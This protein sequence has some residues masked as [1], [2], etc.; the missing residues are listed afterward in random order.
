MSIATLKAYFL[1][2]CKMDAIKQ[3]FFFIFVH[4]RN[5]IFILLANVFRSFFLV[6]FLFL[7]PFFFL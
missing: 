7:F 6:I 5:E 1:A 2:N 3:H 4:M